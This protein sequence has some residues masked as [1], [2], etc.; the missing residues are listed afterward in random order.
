MKK[1]DAEVTYHRM[2]LFMQNAQ[3]RQVHRDRMYINGCQGLWR[4]DSGK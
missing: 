2:I 4:E 1:P 3:N